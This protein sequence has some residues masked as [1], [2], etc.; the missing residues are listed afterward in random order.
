MSKEINLYELHE[1]ICLMLETGDIDEQFILSRS[2]M[3]NPQNAYEHLFAILF[4][5]LLVHKQVR[6]YNHIFI[7]DKEDEHSIKKHKYKLNK[8]NEGLKFSKPK[9]FQD[10]LYH[11]IMVNLHILVDMIRDFCV[12]YSTQYKFNI[13]EEWLVGNSRKEKAIFNQY[14][15]STYKLSR[16]LRNNFYAHETLKNIKEN[17]DMLYAYNKLVD[18]INMLCNYDKKAYELA[19]SQSNKKIIWNNVFFE[20]KV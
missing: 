4:K 11:S 6:E 3:L 19:V 14:C 20:N 8:Y 18:T 16:K 17:D 2:Q 10:A 9:L 1:H 12:K 13:D 7:F 5:T 15:Y